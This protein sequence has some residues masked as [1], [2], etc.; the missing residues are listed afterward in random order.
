MVQEE[1]IK[2]KKKRVL[3]KPSSLSLFA[4]EAQPQM[5][6]KQVCV[7]FFFFL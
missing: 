5:T 4:K 2:K 6:E 3:M 1:G 7:R